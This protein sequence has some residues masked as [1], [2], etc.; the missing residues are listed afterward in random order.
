MT[1]RPARSR[2]GRG[3][4]YARLRAIPFCRLARRGAGRA[5]RGH[6]GDC[7]RHRRIGAAPAT[8]IVQ[9]L[10]PAVHGSVR[11]C[12]GA[13]QRHEPRRNP[14]GDPHRWLSSKWLHLLVPVDDHR[15]LGRRSQEGGASPL[16]APHGAARSG[17][18]L[19]GRFRHRLSPGLQARN[20]RIG[21]TG[22]GR[23]HG[24]PIRQGRRSGE[25]T[26]VHG[27]LLL[28]DPRPGHGAGPSHE[29]NLPRERRAILLTEESR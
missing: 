6:R 21:A 14:H 25:E 29:H 10:A 28:G 8:G 24:L 27:P 3:G 16:C 17:V 11:T 22:D 5:D 13:L 18:P 4:T 12:A 26:G 7:R 20:R 15:S 1:L 2:F 19:S 23:C 9:H